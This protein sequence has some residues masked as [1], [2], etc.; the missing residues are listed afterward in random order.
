MIQRAL[1]SRPITVRFLQSAM[2][3][4]HEF[5]LQAYPD[6][7][8]RPQVIGALSLVYLL[9]T[10]LQHALERGRLDRAGAVTGPYWRLLEKRSAWMP[11]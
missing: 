2:K 7:S 11:E 5:A 8:W 6:W 1:R 4:A 9:G 10:T 3:R